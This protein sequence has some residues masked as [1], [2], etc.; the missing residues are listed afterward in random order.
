M[1]QLVAQ[2]ILTGAGHTVEVVCNGKLAVETL[3][4]RKFDLVLMDCQMPEMDG[5]DAVAL[6]RKHESEGRLSAGGRPLPLI[7]LTANAVKGDRERCL[8]AG[9]T[10]YVSKPVKEEELLGAVDEALNGRAAET[11]PAP[12]PKARSHEHNGDRPIDIEDLLRRCRGKTS[13]AQTLLGKFE[14]QLRSMLSQAVLLLGEHDAPALAKLAHN[15]KGTA[16]N[17]S[18][19]KLRQS[20]AE[21]EKLGVAG[22][23]DALPAALEALEA[24]AQEIIEFLPEATAEVSAAGKSAKG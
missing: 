16:A 21:L 24:Q 2:E 19:E 1:N 20:A 14:G 8:E 6:I 11:A 7:A 15:V 3:L 10:G 4:R 18:A 22:D 23:A 9:M 5:F 13:L 12:K 17:L